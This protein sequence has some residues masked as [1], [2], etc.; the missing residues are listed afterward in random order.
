MNTIT[1][2][3]VTFRT[4]QNQLNTMPVMSTSAIQA[5][6]D[7]RTLGYDVHRVECTYPTV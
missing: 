7:L 4:Q 5:V 6:T 2:Y 1:T 3:S